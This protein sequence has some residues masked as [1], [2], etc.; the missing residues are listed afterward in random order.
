MSSLGNKQTM[1]DNI[2]YY[3]N[4]NNKTRND[5]CR[6]LGFK[7]TTLTGWLTA[8]KYP[9]IDKIEMMANY[10]GITKADLVEERIPFAQSRKNLAGERIKLARQNKQMTLEDVAK[11]VGVTRQTIQK[12]ESGI[13]PNIPSDKIELLASALET[14]PAYLMG[15]EDKQK[16]ASP[17]IGEDLSPL[18]KKLMKILPELNEDQK[19]IGIALLEALLKNK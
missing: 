8:E 16:E 7:Y 19:K 5:L 15:W 17:V 18:D 9:R 3:M 6:D 14:T 13:I 2:L 12:Y 1:A 10:F 11:I 4:I